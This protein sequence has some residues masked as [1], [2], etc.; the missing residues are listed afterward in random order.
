MCVLL[1]AL[2]GPVWDVVVVGLP[3]ADLTIGRGIIVVAAL[4]FVLDVLRAPVPRPR[5]PRA[6]WLLVA[7]LALL[8]V[9][10]VTNALSW[11]CGC[12]VEVAGFSE[13]LA[14]CVLAA[15]ISAFE[16]QLRPA[17]VLAVVAGASLSAALTLAGVHGLSEG[18]ANTSAIQGRAAGPFGNPNLLAFLLAFGLPAGLAAYRPQ[19][20][21]TRLI[22]GGAVGLVTLVLVLTF[23]RSGLLAAAA[24]AVVVLVLQQPRRSRAR[25]RT[26][27]GLGMAAAAI[28]VI[29]PAFAE[30][31]RDASSPPLDQR[32]RALDVSGWDGRAQG[33]IAGG[34][35]RLANSAPG[36]L[37]VGID[38]A[39]EGVSR[40]IG[41]AIA[42]R[43]YEL[44]FEAR[45]VTGTQRLHFGLEDNV[46]GNSPV[47]RQASVSDRW[48]PLRIGWRPTADS[49]D[50]RLYIWSEGGAPGFVIRDVVTVAR[51]PG[52][53]AA[54]KTHAVTLEGSTYA[55]SEAARR[56]FE[57]REVASRRAG[58][59]LSLSAFESQPIRGIGWGRFNEFSAARAEFGRLPT[60]N[61]YLRFLAELGLV[62]VLLLGFVGV[63][64]GMAARSAQR[65]AVG[66]AVLGMLITGAVGL[67]FVNGLATAAVTM[68]L[69][70]A[71]GVAC[72]RAGRRA[73]AGASEATSWWP[74]DAGPR[75]AENGE[76]EVA[77][78]V[79]AWARP[80]TAQFAIRAREL[81][82][83]TLTPAPAGHGVSAGIRALQRAAPAHLPIAIDGEMSRRRFARADERL[84]T[85]NPSRTAWALGIGALALVVRIPIMLQR[86]EV[87]PSEDS[88]EYLSLARDFLAQTSLSSVRPP[89]YPLFLAL[90]G[91]LP[92]RLEDAAV[93][94]QLLIGTVLCATL[95]FVAWPLFGRLAAITAGL[96]TG[97]TAPLLNI[98]SV[99]LSDFLFGATVTVAAGLL[100][101]SALDEQHRT[102]WLLMTGIA[103]AVA[104]YVKPVGH[105]LVLAPVL[106]LAL[107]TRSLRATCFGTGV[108]LAVV[109]VATAPW[110]LRNDLKYGSFT[111]SAQTGLTL[112]NRVFEDDRLPIPTDTPAGRIAEQYRVSH[113]QARLASGVSLELQRLGATRDAAER[114]Q[115][116]LAIEAIR[117]SPMRFAAGTVRSTAQAFADVAGAAGDDAADT[118]LLAGA[119]PAPRLSTYGYRAVEPLRRV[120]NLLALFGLAS[121]AWL[122]SG[123]RRTRVAAG[124]LL[125]VWLS[126]AVGT[127][128]LH[129]GQFRYSAALAPLTWLLGSAGLV[130]AARLVVRLV[131]S[132]SRPATDREPSAV[133]RV[134][135]P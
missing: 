117:R 104:V 53:P 109:A 67:L 125:G 121:L 71:A 101:A 6:V 114:A 95:V 96:L 14:I 16:P 33:L 79:T 29:Y 9:W 51:A 42:A 28:A 5:V 130:V 18:T 123:A 133:G 49:P 129:G 87:L 70:L 10:I 73:A 86:H 31:R 56:E 24:G 50:A 34:E 62:G 55:Q 32:L 90:A 119:E 93:V 45:S 72:G 23:S 120:W 39:G 91:A 128:V 4:L 135:D 113:P 7:A 78:T 89:G 118:P 115:R 2:A 74:A 1:A 85:W 46:R 38:G 41:H 20:G 47:S 60:H 64:I 83:S 63:S 77:R 98:E 106:P 94:A 12:S 54:R 108:V 68:P 66:L 124:A 40:P 59:E 11:G 44:R 99:L 103:I 111:M 48:Q 88:R 122:L 134:T 92:G 57:T 132:A 19:L 107:A 37:E 81:A 8:W 105:A 100:I 116:K 15:F 131:R 97:L 65:D 22:L 43:E 21:R 75:R 80:F 61:E 110:M 35:A 76:R 36:E 84:R 112:F 3:G 30:L 27:V 82:P 69:A 58:V 52:A 25:R 127:A 26:L 17:V 126:V 13:L 102:R